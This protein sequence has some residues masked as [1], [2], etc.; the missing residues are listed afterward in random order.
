MTSVDIQESV[1]I[2][3]KVIEM[4]EGVIYRENF[5]ITPFEKNIDEIFALRKKYEDEGNDVMQ[6]LVKLI[7]NALYGEVL[8]KG[9]LES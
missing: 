1:K 9:T 7:M 5:K 8:R 2:G 6:L 4:Y 3:G